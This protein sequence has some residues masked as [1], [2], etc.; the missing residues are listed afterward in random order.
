LNLGGNETVASLAMTGLTSTISTNGGTF[1]NVTSY[2]N[3][4]VTN[5]VNTTNIYSG[6]DPTI[7]NTAA[8]GQP[9]NGGLLVTNTNTILNYGVSTIQFSQGQQISVGG[10]SGT[11]T[12]SGGSSNFLSLF[13]YWAAGSTNTLISYGSGNL[14]FASNGD[15]INL[16]AY[17]LSN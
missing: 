17:G 4:T 6:L 2:T 15:S 7:S 10:G 1:T 13:G 16:T 3:Y 9:A 11:L 12:I 8:P 14:L 5:G